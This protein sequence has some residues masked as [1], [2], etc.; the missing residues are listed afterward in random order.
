MRHYAVVVAATEPRDSEAS[1]VVVSRRHRPLRR[2]WWSIV[3]IGVTAVT[4]VVAFRIQDHQH[5]W[6]HV[7]Q[8][9]TQNESSTR[10]DLTIGICAP[11][12]VLPT[13]IVHE[14]SSEIRVSVDAHISDRGDNAACAAGATVT[15]RSPIGTR[16]VVDGHSGQYVEVIFTG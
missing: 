5:E 11:S 1:D 16:Q 12:I 14:T 9:V 13:P 4:L 15:L 7:I 10:L 6:V 2:D 8:A 3:A